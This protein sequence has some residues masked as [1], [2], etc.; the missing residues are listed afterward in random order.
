MEVGAR[1]KMSHEVVRA[2]LI[3]FHRH[4]IFLYFQ[5]ILPDVVFLAPQVP[6][7][8]VN[9]IVALAYKVRSVPIFT[10]APKYKRF[11]KEGII[12]E[13]MLLDESFQLSSHF[14]P[15]IYDPKDVI[16]L[17]LHIYAIAPLSSEEPLAKDQPPSASSS[18]PGKMS[19]E[20]REYLMMTLLQ[21]KP[22]ND[23]Q[24]YFP[25]SSKIAPLVIQ[26][27]SG[28]VPNG[29]FGSTVSCL[30]STYNWK[31]SQTKR[32]PECLAHN[33]VTLSDPTL[34]VTVTM[35]N[36]TQHLEIHINTHNVEEEDFSDFCWSIRKTIF[37]AIK[38]NV[39]RLMRFEYLQVK[40]AFLCPC[41][42]DPS[43]VAT[44]CGDP[45][46]VSEDS[47]IVCSETDTSQGRLKKQHLFWFQDQ[48][49]DQKPKLKELF[50]ELV[51]IS[52]KWKHLGIQL[53]LEGKLDNIKSDNP[54]NSQHRLSDVLSTWLK[55]EPG[56]TWHTLC[57]AL[58]SET[59]GEQKLA[60][61]L[62]AKY[63]K[64]KHSCI[65]LN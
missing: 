64:R 59:V 24:E 2:A 38:K 29:C 62:V 52:H 49:L 45:D 23:I 5:H 3:F 37:E 48:V 17:F 50:E 60:S 30:I 14:I 63:L 40:P 25:S 10:L 12:T 27:S 11:C 20:E 26:F 1:L 43:H 54:E 46:I 57:A 22:E 19:S 47:Y 28:C 34:P 41:A 6:L 56:A 31:V 65:D 15:G 39:F 18:T 33:I 8:F 16:K 32:V 7:D 58:R 35:V 4:N 44:I 36:Y 61:D 13:E 51:N 42:C 21:D 9:A 55:V 53:G